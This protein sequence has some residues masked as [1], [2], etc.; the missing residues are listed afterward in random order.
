[1]QDNCIISLPKMVTIQSSSWADRAQKSDKRPKKLLYSANHHLTQAG[2]WLSSGHSHGLWVYHLKIQ[3]CKRCIHM[4]LLVWVVFQFNHHYWIGSAIKSNWLNPAVH[5]CLL[6][7]RFSFSF[8]NR[9]PTCV[10]MNH[11][12]KFSLMVWWMPKSLLYL[13]RVANGSVSAQNQNR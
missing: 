4:C 6:K 5:D 1:M 3:T 12:F 7:S 9:G 8:S 11:L 2:I 13:D 10:H